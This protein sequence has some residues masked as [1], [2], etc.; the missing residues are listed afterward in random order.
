MRRC[1]EG[2]VEKRPDF[3]EVVAALAEGCRIDASGDSLSESSLTEPL[4]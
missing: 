3:G 2:E 1:W 4:Q